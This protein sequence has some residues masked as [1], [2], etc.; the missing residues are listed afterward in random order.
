MTLDVHQV[1]ASKGKRRLDSL[2]TRRAVASV[3]QDVQSSACPGPEKTVMLDDANV[4]VLA[5]F[6]TE[7]RQAGRHG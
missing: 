3:S 1:R 2:Q 6:L 5:A 7:P 4:A